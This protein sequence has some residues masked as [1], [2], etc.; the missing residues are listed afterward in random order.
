MELQTEK[1]YTVEERAKKITR[2]QR[3]LGE[4]V[5]WE[6]DGIGLREEG[7]LAAFLGRV[8]L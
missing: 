7:I 1:Y 8:G 2:K 5:L 3:E 4:S 6:E